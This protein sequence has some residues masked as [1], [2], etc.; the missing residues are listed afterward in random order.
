M[1][2]MARR[3]IMDAVII[4]HAAL[5]KAGRR[6][7]RKLS[8]GSANERR[9]MPADLDTKTAGMNTSHM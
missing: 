2:D 5:S 4:D 1:D 6:T 3:D 8:V 9:A 7:V